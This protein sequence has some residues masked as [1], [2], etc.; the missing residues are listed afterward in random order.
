MVPGQI[1]RNSDIPGQA[2]ETPAEVSEE[3][4][5]EQEVENHGDAVSEAG[6]TTQSSQHGQTGLI[7][8]LRCKYAWDSPPRSY[9]TSSLMARAQGTL[10]FPFPLIF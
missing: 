4:Q 2:E 8:Q 10:P 9:Q 1:L 6:R 5:P 3:G 7:G